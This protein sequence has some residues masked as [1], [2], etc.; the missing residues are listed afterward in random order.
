MAEACGS[1]GAV[2]LLLGNDLSECLHWRLG[3][4]LYMYC[5]TVMES[6]RRQR[7]M[8]AGFF[9]EVSKLAVIIS[10]VHEMWYCIDDTVALFFFCM[11]TTMMYPTC[12]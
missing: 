8:D 2:P 4:L 1:P 11:I 3:A 5:H 12:C 9:M 7:E 10:F 6:E